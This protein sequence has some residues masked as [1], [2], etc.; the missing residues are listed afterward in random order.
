[1]EYERFEFTQ[2]LYGGVNVLRIGDSLVDTG[3]V[4]SVSRTAVAAALD[5]ELAGIDRVLITHPHIDHV[6]G[7]Q[8]IDELAELPHVV[9]EGSVEILTDYAG[10]LQR[11][12]E[13][14]TRLLGGFGTD[15][16]TW[17]TYFPVREDYAEERIRINRELGDGDTIECGGYDLTAVSTPGHADPHLAFHHEPSGTLFSGDLVDRDGR[18]QYG[19]L[20]GEV[21]AYKR[22]LRRIRDLDPDVLVPMHGPPMDDPAAR[23][24]T[25]LANADSTERRLLDFLDRRGPCF[26][27][28][29][30]ADELGV[31]GMRAP[32]LTLVVYEYLRYLE[33]RKKVT[34]EVTVEGIEMSAA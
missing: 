8:T 10:Y 34:I 16:A 6:G 32:F 17:D 28:A 22:S 18:F 33:K 24:D 30:V 2:P 29:F 11:A 9:P 14:M 21:G 19:P 1:M 12:R 25:S 27:R 31:D 4:A 7:S 20:L 26:A 23:I 3:H 5:D 13:E 15:A